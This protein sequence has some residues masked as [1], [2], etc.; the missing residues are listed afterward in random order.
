LGIGGII[1]IA[2]EKEFVKEFKDKEKEGKEIIKEKDLKELKDKEAK[3]FIKEK[4]LKEVKEKDVFDKNRDKALEKSREIIGGGGGPEQTGAVSSIETR[5]QNIE[6]M[7]Q[8]LSHFISS[9]NRPDLQTSLFNQGS[10]SEEEEFQ[11]NSNDAKTM[12]DSKEMDTM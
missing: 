11:K 5:L 3:E 6:S 10:G 8:Q 1:K 12:N 4:E 2:K 9:E 7:I